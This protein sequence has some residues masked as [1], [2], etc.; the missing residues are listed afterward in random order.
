V[1][2]FRLNERSSRSLENPTVPLTDLSLVSL[3]GGTPTD[4]GIAVTER[5]A[6]SMAA[7]YRATSLISGLCGALPMPVMDETTKKPIPNRLLADPH[8][9]MTRLEIWRLSGAHRCLWGNSYIQ[10]LYNKRGQVVEL[11]PITPDRV[12]PG[13]GRPTAENPSGKV[14]SVIDDSGKT[15]PMTSREI[16]HITAW[17]HDPVLGLS[18]VRA[19]SQAVGLSLAAERYGA[20]LFG[21]GNLISGLLQAEGKL[22]QTQAESLQKRWAERVSGLENA[23]K[24]PVLDSGA[25]FQSM[26]MPSRDAE[27][28]ASRDFEVTELCRFFGIPPYLMFQTE[29][30]TS[31]GCV[32]GH[33]LV[34]TTTGPKK[35][36]DIE[37][38][39]E[40]WS[41]SQGGMVPAKVTAWHST[42]YKSLL[43]IKTSTREL[44]VTANHRV[45]VRRYFG[46][47]DGRINGQ[48][49]WETV[50]ISAGEIKPG[51]FLLAPNGLNDGDR[52]VAPNGRELTVRAME[53]CGLYTGDGSADKNRVEIAH[54]ID[55]PHMP[56]YIESMRGEFGVKPYTDKRGTRTRFSSAQAR[57]L[58]E[59]G[60]TG[61]AHTKR[62]PGW[63][64]RLNEELRLAFLRGYLDADGGVARG[65]I[66]FASCNQ[67]LLEDIRH[68]CISVGVPVG[69]VHLSRRGGIGYIK[70]KSHVSRDKHVL[71]LSMTSMNHKIGSNHPNKLANLRTEP[72][73][74]KLR[75]AEDWEGGL[76]TTARVKRPEMMMTPG[77]TWEHSDVVLQRVISIEHGKIEVPVYDITVEEHAHY[78][79]DG[80]VVHNTGL[81]QQARGFTA[82]DL[83]PIWLAPAE[84]RITKELVTS[85]Q[86]ARYDMSEL[87]R[88]DS[89]ARAEFYR[90]MFELGAFNPNEIRG[91]EDMPAREGGDRY[92]EPLT[93]LA[94]NS[95]LGTD[96]VLGGSSMGPADTGTK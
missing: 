72:M 71:N 8:P 86:V 38:G 93:Q 82:Y 45:P 33:T 14:F 35:I 44:Q 78:V 52:R 19:A 84:Q 92:Q 6:Q 46:K 73:R 88:G 60:F 49:A 67:A 23:H 7:V 69:R 24:I 70:G 27:M 59:C 96:P 83:H 47:A 9:D 42:G 29:K 95:P 41:F 26:T 74:R 3:F 30:T 68:L 51:D 81:E 61:K 75:Y 32:P 34:F 37:P 66:S 89:I 39:E 62:V 79:A 58:F 65:V 77:G 48:C 56:Y 22:T 17:G 63:V 12:T 28:L 94:V 31:W 25:K 40:V 10:K 20:K 4:S 50:E 43:T 57:S 54:A 16:L 87:L 1:T 5:T 36:E 21:S 85:G 13:R 55:D 80:V 76:G 64:F 18:P 15:V 11:W 53:L 2:L 91:F 90:V